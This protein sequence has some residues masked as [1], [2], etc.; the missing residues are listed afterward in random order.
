MS[1]QFSA[2]IGQQKKRR[3]LLTG[4]QAGIENRCL[5]TLFEQV[6]P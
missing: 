5:A 1:L 4:E 6:C 3:K 2:F